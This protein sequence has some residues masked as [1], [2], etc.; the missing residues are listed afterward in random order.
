MVLSLTFPH[1]NLVHTFPFLHTCHMPRPSHSSRFITRTI[2]GEENRSLSSLL[3]NFLHSPVT[4]YRVTFTFTIVEC[5]VDVRPT[6]D[7][8]WRNSKLYQLGMILCDSRT[9]TDISWKSGAAWDRTQISWC[10]SAES[11]TMSTELSGLWREQT[12]TVWFYRKSFNIEDVIRAAI[13]D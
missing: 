12:R 7:P 10:S 9:S 5:C 3:C 1:Q 2:L 8:L 6:P 11:I 13:C 4:P